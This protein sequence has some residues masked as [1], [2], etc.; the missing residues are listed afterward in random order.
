MDRASILIWVGLLLAII[1]TILSFSWNSILDHVIKTELPVSP[2]SKTYPLWEESIVGMDLY[3]FNWTNPEELKE[4]NFKP[5]LVQLGP[6]RFKQV[7]KKINVTWNSN[8]TVTYKRIR[9]WYYDPENSNG[10]L[11]DKIVM[12]NVIPLTASYIVRSWS[13]FSAIPVSS[14]VRMFGK[15]V[16][17]T[18]T[19]EQLLFEGYDDPLLTIATTL[20]GLSDIYIPEDKV[21]WF[22][23]RNGSINFDG[24]FNVHTAR[25][26]ITKMGNVFNWNFEKNTPFF[27]GKCSEVKGSV[28]DLFPPGQTRDKSINMFSPDV[29]RSF[30]LDYFEDVETMEMSGYKYVASKSLVD[31]GTSYTDSQ[32]NCNGD[33]LPAGVFN[34]S[35]CRYGI[36]L[37]ISYPHFY[38]ADPW[39][40]T[41]VNGLNPNAD[42]HQFRITLEPKTGILLDLK[43]RIQLNLLLQP[44]HN[45]GLFKGLPKIMFPMLW[46]EEN[47]QLPRRE[48]AL[49]RLLV[50]MPTIGLYISVALV[51]VGIFILAVTILPMLLQE[52]HWNFFNRLK[53]KSCDMIANPQ[54]AFPKRCIKSQDK[55][56]VTLPEEEILLNNRRTKILIT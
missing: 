56:D 17:I 53:G 12:I 20:P 49:V 19:A 51:L 32:C 7:Y 47:Y 41:Q 11:T 16:W 36:P 14:G 43:A 13:T 24:V 8:N 25:D 27:D 44:S 42:D 4:K 9:N 38:G 21:G 34:I 18:R 35:S 55:E 48:A 37:F 15:T 30:S 45:V 39:Y 1:G 5:E 50:L 31:N 2:T 46:F 26:D 40:T 33:C 3:F 29:C 54:T 52:G 22:Y 28:G 23:N 10:S 6:Y